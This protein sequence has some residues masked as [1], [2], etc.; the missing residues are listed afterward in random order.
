MGKGKKCRYSLLSEKVLHELREYF[1]GKKCRYS[2]LSEK[3][4]HELR[5]YFK[6]TKATINQQFTAER[7]KQRK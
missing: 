6:T 1:K 5:E 2:L 4:L 3:V 7:Q